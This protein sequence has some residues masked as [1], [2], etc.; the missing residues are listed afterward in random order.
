M[1]ELSNNIG[2]KITI[3]IGG[4][5]NRLGIRHERKIFLELYHLNEENL[6]IIADIYKIVL[7]RAKY[8]R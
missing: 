8:L 5:K 6:R 1:Y 3:L 7:V 2:I 4:L